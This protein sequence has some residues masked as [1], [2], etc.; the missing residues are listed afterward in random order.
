MIPL[1]LH[2]IKICHVTILFFFKFQHLPKRK[3]KFILTSTN[4]AFGQW[5]FWPR[6]HFGFFFF[7]VLFS[8]EYVLFSGSRAR[9]T[10]TLLKKKTIKN[11]FYGSIHI[12]KNYFT[13]VFLVFNKIS[14]IEMDSLSLYLS[15]PP[16]LFFSLP[17]KFVRGAPLSTYLLYFFIAVL[18]HRFCISKVTIIFF[19]LLTRKW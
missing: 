10:S 13:I 3:V 7:E 9:L 14:S 11:G 2:S 15:T 19:G 16:N 1:N 4:C 12:F 5:W 18:G 6:L 17:P 8:R